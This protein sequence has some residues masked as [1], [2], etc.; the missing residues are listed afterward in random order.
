MLEA[1][2]RVSQGRASA[3]SCQKK[4][5][6]KTKAPSSHL[7]KIPVKHPRRVAINLNNRDA[8]TPPATPP[9]RTQ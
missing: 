1:Y 2:P 4:K 8:A 7:D 3:D 5:K 6:R 9:V